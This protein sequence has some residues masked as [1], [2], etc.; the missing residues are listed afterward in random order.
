MQNIYVDEGQA[1]KAGQV[2]FRI[3]PKMYEAELAKAQSEARMA[4]IEM[5]NTKLLSDKD[6][7]SKNEL[8]MAKAKLAQANSEIA[9]AKLHLSFTEIR[10]P[11]DGTIDRIPLKLGSL[12]D[13][14]ICSP[15][16]R[17]TVRCLPTSTYLNPNTWTTRPTLRTAATARFPCF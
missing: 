7:V 14:E 5:Q 16:C 17:T 2:L 12:I 4:E 11:F 10:A 15:A 8:A 1:V 13:E 9:M 3:M 6:V